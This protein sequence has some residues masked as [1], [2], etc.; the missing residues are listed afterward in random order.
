MDEYPIRTIHTRGT[1]QWGLGLESVHITIMAV[2]A[3]T[4]K[5][6]ALSGNPHGL[7]CA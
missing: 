6:T 5:V 4:H 1:I 7:L 2:R 3:H